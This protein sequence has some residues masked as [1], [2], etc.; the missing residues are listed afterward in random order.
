MPIKTNKGFPVNFG[1]PLFLFTG[2]FSF[3]LSK[4]VI[5]L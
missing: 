1:S 4:F 2:D 5:L 3:I